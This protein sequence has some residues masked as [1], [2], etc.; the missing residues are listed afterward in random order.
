MVFIDTAGR[1]HIDEALMEELKRIRAAVKPTEILLAVDAMTGQDAVNVA[2]SFNEALEIDGVVLTKMDGDTRGGAALS[3]RYIT[4]KPIKF[5]GTG[6]KLD[7]IEPFYPDRMASRILGMG[8]MLTLIEKAQEQFDEKQAKELER[9]IREQRFDLNDFLAQLAQMKNMGNLTA[10]SYTHLD[11]YKRQAVLPVSARTGEGVDALKAELLARA[12]EG[13]AFFP[14][15]Q[16]TDQSER[17]MVA[18]IIRE[19]ALLLLDQEIPHGIAVDILTFERKREAFVINADLYCEKASHKGII[20]GRGGAML[21]ELS[22]RA[23]REMEQL[24]GAKVYLK[25]WVKVRESWRDSDFQL[26]A[27][28]F[29]KEN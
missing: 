22:S 10:V 12:E 17:E 29:T 23:R 18:E 15:E 21:K 7:Q 6:E 26:G 27:L 3:V 28:G 1:L 11:V 8:D 2:E 4:G 13:P 19:K 14:P 16:Y 9:K 5:V 24:L 25:I 20:I